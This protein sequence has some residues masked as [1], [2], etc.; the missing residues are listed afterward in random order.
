MSQRQGLRLPCLHVQ[1]QLMG[2]TEMGGL[3]DWFHIWMAFGWM[4]TN[5]WAG[6]VWVEVKRFG[7]VWFLVIDFWIQIGFSGNLKTTIELK[8]ICLGFTHIITS[9]NFTRRFIHGDLYEFRTFIFRSFPAFHYICIFHHIFS[10]PTHGP[11]SVAAPAG[12][13]PGSS[14]RI[15]RHRREDSVRVG[16]KFSSYFP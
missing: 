2:W 15:C 5:Y 1:G 12:L 9:K 8:Y 10:Y 16:M 7:S 6:L 4:E 14:P 3:M 13:W 11:S